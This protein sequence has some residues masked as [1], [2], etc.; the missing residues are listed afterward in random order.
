[1]FVPKQF[2]RRYI[3]DIVEPLYA[4][5]GGFQQFVCSL[6]PQHEL[7]WGDEGRKEVRDLL[8]PCRGTNA[9][10]VFFVDLVSYYLPRQTSYSIFKVSI[11]S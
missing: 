3:N 11:V 4:H 2:V 7:M 10:K 9:T 5:R 6:S 1:M 8:W